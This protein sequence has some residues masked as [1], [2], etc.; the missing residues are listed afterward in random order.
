MKFIIVLVALTLSIQTKAL[1]VR[2][3]LSKDIAQIVPTVVPILQSTYSKIGLE[4][5]FILVPE[6]R[7][8]NQFNIGDC[9]TLFLKTSYIENILKNGTIINVQLGDPID[10]VIW[11][12]KDSDPIPFE[13]S[14]IIHRR[15]SIFANNFARDLKPRKIITSIN[16]D[17]S[18]LLLKKRRADYFIGPKVTKY[19][20]NSTDFTYLEKPKRSVELYHYISNTLLPYKEKI[21]KE[22]KEQI[23]TNDF[24]VE[25]AIRNKKRVD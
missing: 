18:F 4:S 14:S 2:H 5:H 11:M 3:C 22:L 8:V 1:I 10:Y 9:D 24:S 13:Q 23:I 6:I 25:K 20:Y 16:M 19:Y 7:L 12:L 21:T 15:G 17:V